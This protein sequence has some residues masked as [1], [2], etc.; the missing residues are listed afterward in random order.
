MTDKEKR[1][2][3]YRANFLWGKTDDFSQLMYEF[4]N[5]LTEEYQEEVYKDCLLY[6]SPSPRD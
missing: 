5:A 1:D 2:M 4:A 6:T 3:K